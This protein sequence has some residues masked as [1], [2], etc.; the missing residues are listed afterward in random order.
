[1]QQKAL[2]YCILGFTYGTVAIS[3][4]SFLYVKDYEDRVYYWC[5][6]LLCPVMIWIWVV[7][8]WSAFEMFRN[9]K[10]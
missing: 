3:I 6:F 1:M 9:V 4:L 10:R 5:W 7:R 2:G 8:A